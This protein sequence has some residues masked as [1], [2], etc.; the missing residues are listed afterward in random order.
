MN[1]VL[2]REWKG[3]SSILGQDNVHEDNLGCELH[4]G[5]SGLSQI[6]LVQIQNKAALN[7][8]IVKNKDMFK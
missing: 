2:P 3:P 1:Y 8:L 4:F 6:I 7:S 5:H